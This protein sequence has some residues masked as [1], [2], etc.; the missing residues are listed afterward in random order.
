MWGGWF[1]PGEGEALPLVLGDFR[2]LRDGRRVLGAA[3]RARV[4]G[5]VEV[6][7]LVVCAL[8]FGAAGEARADALESLMRQLR[9]DGDYKVRLSAALALGRQNDP[10]AIPALVYSLR[11][12]FPTVRAV[13][14]GAL[15]KLL[16]DPRVPEKYRK[17]AVEKLRSLAVT[18]SDAMVKGAAANAV[19]ALAGIADSGSGG[20]RAT[21]SRSPSG[22]I[23]VHVDRFVDTSKT[24]NRSSLSN[25]AEIVREALKAESD[26]MVV[27][28]PG[29][30]LPS[31]KALK[32]A[33]T[34]GA[35]T[36]LGTMSDLT[37]VSKGRR[38]FVTCRVK[39]IV[40]TY[41]EKAARAFINGS[42][43]L[44]TANSSGAIERAKENC[45]RDVIRHLV[46]KQVAPEFEAKSR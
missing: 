12:S 2:R 5:R 37:V 31:K 21:G 17:Q 8:L 15:G 10:R 32:K 4:S 27:R 24:M 38:A 44:E 16:Q 40:A 22:N 35:F 14:A 7:L 36:L 6:G 43:K 9:T 41:P 20:G 29:G 26:A 3:I 28:W 13:S 39:F 46:K 18:D 1:D 30:K 25:L 34:R 33:K 23:F 11:D 45:A 42:A 19:K